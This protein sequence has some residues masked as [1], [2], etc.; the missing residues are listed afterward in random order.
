MS[1]DMV[2]VTEMVKLERRSQASAEEKCIVA[3]NRQVR[4]QMDRSDGTATHEGHVAYADNRWQSD[5]RTAVTAI[6][7]WSDRVKREGVAE[8]TLFNILYAAGSMDVHERRGITECFCFNRR[9][10]WWKADGD[11]RMAAFKCALG[12]DD[13]LCRDVDE[14]ALGLDPT[15]IRVIGCCRRHEEDEGHDRG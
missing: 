7:G 8:G 15:R 14:P 10:R 6:D 2:Q 11:E 4:A 3:K 13:G 12:N 5:T 1:A 9:H